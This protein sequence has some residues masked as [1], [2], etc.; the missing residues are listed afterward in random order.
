LEHWEGPDGPAPTQSRQGPDGP[1]PTQSRQGPDGPAPTQSRQGPDGPAPTQSR[2]GP[3]GP[4][5]TQSRQGPD[6]PAPTQS[7]QGPD[8]PAPTQSRQEHDLARISYT[9][10]EG[11]WHFQ[12]C[13]AIV[14]QD[15]EDAIRV[16]HQAVKT[17]N[18]TRPNLFWGEVPRGFTSRRAMHE[19]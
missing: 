9:L 7:R 18:A 19:L 17:S 1:A 11:R 3:D 12:H 2:Q 6:G 15:R 5:P 13:C 14:I 4:A 8:G 16:W 10:S